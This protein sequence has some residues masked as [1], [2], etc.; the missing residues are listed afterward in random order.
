[1]KKLLSTILFAAICASEAFAAVFAA[2]DKSVYVA[3]DR[4]WCSV[5]CNDSDA[6]AYLDLRS[7]TASL[8]TAKAALNEGRGACDL[9]VPFDI[10]TGNYCLVCYTSSGSED[11]HEI[12]IY[13]TFTLD[14]KKDGFLVVKKLPQVEDKSIFAAG[15]I[16]ALSSGGVRVRRENN[17]VTLTN[18]ANNP[19]SLSVSVS[20]ADGMAQPARHSLHLDAPRSSAGNE[21]DGEIIHMSFSGQKD[22]KVLNS[23][24]VVLM[25]VMGDPEN[26]STTPL[27]GPEVYMQTENIYG[28]T[29]L[30]LMVDTAGQEIDE[31]YFL[32]TH[33]KVYEGTVDNL[34]RIILCPDNEDA[35]LRRARAVKAD[36]RALKDTILTSLPMRSPHLLMP[37]D[38][39]S[40]VL[41]D[42]NR[43]PTM[44]EEVVEI[45]KSVRIRTDNRQRK[46]QTLVNDV[47]KGTQAEWEEALL[48]V[49]G[50]PVLDHRKMIE[51]DPS[52]VKRVDIYSHKY[53]LGYKMYKGIIN[54]VTFKGNVPGM[55][56]DDNTRIYDYQGCSFP[57]IFR[58]AH[59]L[60]WHP[61]LE[62]KPGESY[63]VELDNV[64]S[65]DLRIEVNSIAR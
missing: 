3:G 65:R 31:K 12:S 57:V 30:V 26:L 38:K 29:N 13:N 21:V 62:L 11:K 35:L 23:S 58:G 33:P 10:P 19:L 34:G 63:T 2:T 9:L 32:I 5:F 20:Y 60:Y 17:T 14:R 37:E 22:S 59:T 16:L 40:Y 25:G 42:Y 49:D 50:V 51:Y 24:S 54:F 28:N 7:E 48:L 27:T 56:F 44:E 52:L 43:F 4:I 64:K 47:V 46:F 6:I 39:V 41:D 15:R 18:T 61:L 55:F 1:M 45:L 36:A 53:I 8:S